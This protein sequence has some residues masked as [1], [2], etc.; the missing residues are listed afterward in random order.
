[1]GK[2]IGATGQL[3]G[4]ATSGFQVQAERT[5][6]D[7]EMAATAGQLERVEQ[8]V[9]ALAISRHA[10]RLI[11]LREVG[12]TVEYNRRFVLTPLNEILNQAAKAFALGV[13][14]S[15][16]DLLR[17]FLRRALDAVMK[18]SDPRYEAI[19]RQIAEADLAG[20]SAAGE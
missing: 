13:A 19:A 10:G 4:R 1:M 7:N 20:A 16:P 15:T 9:V 11:T 2:V 12:Y 3:K 17:P 6:L 5:D 8:E 18:P 14:D